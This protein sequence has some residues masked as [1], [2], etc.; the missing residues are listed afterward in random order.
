MYDFIYYQVRDVMTTDLMTVRGEV[1]LKAAEEIFEK[2]DFNGLPVIDP[3]GRLIGMVTKL[4]LLKTFV[5]TDKVKVPPY[6]NLMSKSISTVMTRDVRIVDPE[7]P[8]TRILQ[9]MIDTRNKSFPVVENDRLVGIIA[10]EDVLGA[11]HQAAEGR[12]PA[13]MIESSA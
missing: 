11:L 12:L 4:D 13:R 6:Q 3:E 1:Q 10:R 7:T 5:F 2:H 8:L 9:L